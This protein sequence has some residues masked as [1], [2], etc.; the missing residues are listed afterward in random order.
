MMEKT[1]GRRGGQ[2]RMRRLDSIT[3]SVD[4]T[5]QSRGDGEGQG[6]LACMLQRVGHDLAT[7]HHQQQLL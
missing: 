5:R 2:Q 1:E 3:D 4:M 7:E 6:G